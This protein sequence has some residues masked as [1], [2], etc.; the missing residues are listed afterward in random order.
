MLGSAAIP[1]LN[2]VGRVMYKSVLKKIIPHIQDILNKYMDLN[3]RDRKAISIFTQGLFFKEPCVLLE[4]KYNKAAEAFILTSSIWKINGRESGLNYTN[5][6]HSN[7]ININD[8]L[9]TIRGK[10]LPSKL[11]AI[12]FAADKVICLLQQ[13]FN[14]EHFEEGL[15]SDFEQSLF[16]LYVEFIL[17]LEFNLM[18]FS[19]DKTVES[20]KS[21]FYIEYRINQSDYHSLLYFQNY[22]K[23]MLPMIFN[24]LECQEY[25]RTV[26]ILN[27][28][29]V[30]NL[31]Y[32]NKFMRLSLLA[33]SC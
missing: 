27:D 2:D 17:I 3:K 4:K 23:K 25:E 22:Q 12:L 32:R 7:F 6:L 21:P 30:L 14:I 13:I 9:N 24:L 5:H 28:A 31:T 20:K 16:L 26:N 1:R 33:P 18:L 8:A 15:P 19:Y 10:I 29:A 11:E